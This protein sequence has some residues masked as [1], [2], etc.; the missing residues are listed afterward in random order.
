MFNQKTPA[1]DQVQS[2]KSSKRPVPIRQGQQKTM[3]NQERPVEDSSDMV[4][5]RLAS[6][7]SVDSYTCK[8]KSSR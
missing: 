4:T 5:L 7:V 6:N 8:D 2:G 3:S 1:K